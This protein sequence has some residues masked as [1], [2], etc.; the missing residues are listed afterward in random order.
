MNTQNV[1]VKTATKESSE[2]WVKTPAFCGQVRGL[3]I[4]IAWGKARVMAVI[5][6]KRAEDEMSEVAFE[7]QVAG[8]HDYRSDSDTLPHMFADVPELAAAWWHGR[9]HAAVSDEMENCSGCNNDRG[10]PCPYHD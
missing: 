7:A 4:R 8:Y 1:N 9:N 6:A 2:R 3:N 5:D 10:E